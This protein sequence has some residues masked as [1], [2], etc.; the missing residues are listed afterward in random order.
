MHVIANVAKAK[1]YIR[2]MEFAKMLYKSRCILQDGHKQSGLYNK[3]PSNF[4]FLS[5]FLNQSEIERKKKLFRS[6]VVVV[7]KQR[8]SCDSGHLLHMKLTFM[9][10]QA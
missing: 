5:L 8:F 10:G 9:A 6:C 4:L 1:R 3:I 2:Y 7:C